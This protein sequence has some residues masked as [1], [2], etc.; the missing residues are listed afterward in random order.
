M[1]LFIVLPLLLI[2]YYAFTD[3]NGSF[4]LN[5]FVRFLTENES[6]SSFIMSIWVGLITTVCCLLI[7]Y[8]VAYILAR[9]KIVKGKGLI[10]LFILPM[11]VNF[12]LRT[13]ATRNLFESLNIGLGEFTTVFGMVYNFLPFMILPIYTTLLKMD[14]SLIEAAQDLGANTTNIFFRV[15]FPLSV[16]G[17][18][19]GVL[20]VFM[21]TIS[22]YAIA[23][24]L[25]RNTFQLF[26]NLINLHMISAQ[27]WNYSS[28]LSIIMLAIVGLIMAFSN[29]ERKEEESGL[30]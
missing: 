8:P 6:R 15:I 24:L 10:V 19:S 9:T 2:I 12:L 28:A 27:N 16:P 13:L 18:L 4:T 22:T 21:P 11:W 20:M 17:V 29:K 1:A 3:K 14:K 26:G 23:D 7:G 25:S 5:N 30:W